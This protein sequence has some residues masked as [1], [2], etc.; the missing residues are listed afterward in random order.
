MCGCG[1]TT[2][3]EMSV[4][5]EEKSLEAETYVI[6][7]EKEPDTETPDDLS[8][9]AGNTDVLQGGPYGEISISLPDGW[10]YELCP[11]DNDNLINGMY[12]IHFYPNDVT[13]GYIEI[14]YIDSFGVC[15]TGLEEENAMIAGE[16][17][18]I[19][20]YDNHEYWDFIA[21]D[22]E[23]A[24]MVAYT[25]RVDDWWS[26]YSGQVLD[27]LDTLLFDRNVKEGGA[28][29]YNDESWIEE[30]D[31]YFSLKNISSTGATLVFSQHDADAP[32]GELQYGEDYV[33]EVKKSGEWEKAPIVVKG[34]YGFDAIA[35]LLPCGQ[36]SEREIDWEWLYGEL[37]PGEYRIG[38]S[39]DDFIESGKYDEYMVYAHFILN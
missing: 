14:S 5:Q 34:N 35:I 39:V 31:L 36:I 23:Y 15:G 1:N 12:G 6:Q 13:D 37:E 30:I 29:V 24:G 17:A 3:T 19:G 21:F 33:I 7:T 20:T 26:E 28:Y 11:I 4:A 22:G 27:I 10:G 25:Y 38:K 32:K 18:N 8:V 9:N 2:Q 16:P